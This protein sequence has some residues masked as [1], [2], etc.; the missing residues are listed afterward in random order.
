MLVYIFYNNFP[1]VEFL[2][3]G[4]KHL[5][6]YIIKLLI[7]E[8]YQLVYQQSIRVPIYHTPTKNVCLNFHSIKT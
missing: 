7:T 6:L 8:F 5:K 2:D 4:Y 3:P 1:K